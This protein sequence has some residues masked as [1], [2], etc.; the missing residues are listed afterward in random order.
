MPRS[1]GVAIRSPPAGRVLSQVALAFDYHS[2]VELYDRW[3]AELRRHTPP[4]LLVW[5]RNDPFFPESGAHAYLRDLPEAELH[6]FDTGH[7]ALEECL[8]Q[9]APLIADFLDRTRETQ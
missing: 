9:M 2:N 3:Q 5:G 6:L 8:P 7:F 4:A 1:W